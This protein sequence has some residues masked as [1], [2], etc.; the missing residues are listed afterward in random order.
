MVS[1]RFMQWHPR[2]NT[3]IVLFWDY[4]SLKW[5]CFSRSTTRFIFS[6]SCL[7]FLEVDLCP[8]CASQNM[9]LRQKMLILKTSYNALFR[10]SIHSASVI[11][12]CFVGDKAVCIHSPANT[13][14]RQNEWIVL[15]LLSQCPGLWNFGYSG[16]HPLVFI[17]IVFIGSELHLMVPL[18]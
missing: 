3:A 18:Y 1:S 9:H 6:H 15:K 4:D 14:S 11:L 7:C 8:C 12:F 13:A 5:V 17:F 2:W 16:P 10:G